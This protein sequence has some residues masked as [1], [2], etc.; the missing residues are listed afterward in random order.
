MEKLKANKSAGVLLQQKRAIDGRL[1]WSKTGEQSG[2][3]Y[4]DKNP[5]NI[6]PE[7]TLCIFAEEDARKYKYTCSKEHGAKEINSYN[8]RQ[9][10]QGDLTS[11]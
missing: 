4:N 5:I 10:I 3:Y 6:Y 8:N 11:L 2:E 7:L 9:A 1:L